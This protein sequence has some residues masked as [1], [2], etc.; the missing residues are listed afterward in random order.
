[1]TA[2]AV[3]LNSTSASSLSHEVHPDEHNS[4]WLEYISI[5]EST[6]QSWYWTAAWQTMEREAEEDLRVGRYREF[7]DVEEFIRFLRSNDK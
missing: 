3:S 6:D 4:H 1:M 5:E 2:F 7:D